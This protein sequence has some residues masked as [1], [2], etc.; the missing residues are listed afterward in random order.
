MERFQPCVNRQMAEMSGSGLF[1][2]RRGKRTMFVVL[3]LPSPADVPPLFEP[4]FMASRGDRYPA[5]HD[6][7]DLRKGLSSL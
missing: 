7:D 2:R 4:L 3:D 5:D 1:R 6:L